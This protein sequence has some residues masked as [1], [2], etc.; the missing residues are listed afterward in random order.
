MLRQKKKIYVGCALTHAPEKFRKDVI[1]LKEELRKHYDV[2][3]FVGLKGLT[4]RKVYKHDTSCV[5][6]CDLFVSICDYP[7]LGLGF[8]LGLAVEIG[9][10]ILAFAHVDS[11]VSRLVLGVNAKK[12]KF[13]R[14]KTFEEIAKF[15][16]K[17]P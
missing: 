17:A 16:K 3:D 13:I 4:P 9:K 12:Y 2:L 15:I 7:S 6:S 10:P 8:E 5:R 14:Y 11:K 1:L